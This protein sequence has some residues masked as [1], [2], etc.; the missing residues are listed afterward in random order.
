MKTLLQLNRELLR[1]KEE[2]KAIKEAYTSA[3]QVNDREQ[4]FV[5]EQIFYAKASVN[6]D[7]IEMG[8]SILD[9]RFPELRQGGYGMIYE[10]LITDA[11][12]DLATGCKKLK[13]VYF[14][15]KRYEGFDQ[16]EDHKY[17]YGPRHGYIYQS[18]GLKNPERELSDEQIEA[19][20]YTLENIDVVLKALNHRICES[21]EK[22]RI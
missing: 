1:L 11:K 17:G 3:M 15:Q 13:T 4:K 18:I 10:S 22:E 5:R 8:K 14:G 20:L 12:Q 19:C 7:M 2:E 6:A 21:L 16:R 9:L